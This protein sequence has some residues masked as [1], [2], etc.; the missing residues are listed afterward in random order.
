MI[1]NPEA[2]KTRTAILIKY[3]KNLSA[4][5]GPTTNRTIVSSLIYKEPLETNQKK[6]NDPVEKLANIN[7]CSILKRKYQ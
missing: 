6:T 7:T 1:W 5:I 3:F 2:I 4:I